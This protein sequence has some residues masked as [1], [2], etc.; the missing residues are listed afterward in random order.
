MLR[1]LCLS[2]FLLGVLCGAARA[3]HFAI[4]LDVQARNEKATAHAV[5]LGPGQKKNSRPIL[6]L[7]AGE[8]VHAKWQLTNTHPKSSFKDVLVHFFVVKEDQVGQQ[9]VPKLGKTVQAESALTMDFRPGDK[10]RGELSF[11]I[12]GPGAYLLRLETVGAA[13][14]PE[15]HEH[16]AAMDLVV[17]KK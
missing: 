3:E 12:D 10:T 17:E 14:A 8:R 13:I 1:V 2:S 16:Y 11:V 6:H 7:K 9:T 4:D 15:T 5:K